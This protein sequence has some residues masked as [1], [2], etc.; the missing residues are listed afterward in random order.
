MLQ[1]NVFEIPKL[2]YLSF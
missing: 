2:T 1:S